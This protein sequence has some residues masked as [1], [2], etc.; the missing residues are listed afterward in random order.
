MRIA[1]AAI[2]RGARL[3]ATNDDPTY[4]T[5]DGP[6]PG[7]GA[8]LASIVTA[9]GVA[10][11]IAG[12]PHRPIV[13]HVRRILGDDGIMVG[14]RPDTDGQF[15]YALGYRF[16]LVLSGVTSAADLPWSRPHIW[17]GRIWRPSSTSQLGGVASRPRCVLDW[18]DAS[19]ARRLHAPRLSGRR[20]TR[21]GYACFPWSAAWISDR[22]SGPTQFRCKKRH[23]PDSGCADG[24]WRPRRSG[25]AWLALAVYG[26]RSAR[27][28]QRPVRRVPPH[29]SRCGGRLA[30][31]GV[32]LVVSTAEMAANVLGGLL[33][34][35]ARRR[36]N[37]TRTSGRADTADRWGRQVHG[38]ANAGREA[39]GPAGCGP[40]RPDRTAARR[41]IDRCPQRPR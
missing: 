1:S 35:A 8:I 21:P 7:G 16:A 13:D 9:S 6:V 18:F 27:T 2:R 41:S 37:R 31:M 33:R 12:K 20:V 24:R 29:R 22:Y 14:D 10:P 23:R 3:L 19:A 25:G 30:R 32:Q 36:P 28:G 4:P 34:G 38:N 40:R 26:R 5:P 39:W 15:G 17:W 11:I